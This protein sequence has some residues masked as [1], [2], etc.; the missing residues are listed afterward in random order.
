VATGQEF[1]VVSVLGQEGQ[2]VLG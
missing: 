2:S 1:G